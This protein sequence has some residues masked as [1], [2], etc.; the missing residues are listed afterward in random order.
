MKILVKFTLLALALC[1]SLL[2]AKEVKVSSPDGKLIFTIN[3]QAEVP[4]YSVSFNGEQVIEPS[5]LGMVF[6]SGPYFDLGFNITDSNSKSVNT[7]WQQPWGER[8][9]IT[10][11]HNELQVTIAAD[12][13]TVNTYAIY[14]YLGIWNTYEYS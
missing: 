1:S 9:T 12:R 6:K 2:A 3:D 10:D 14:L 13:E 4:K 8:E 11:H 5:R 7:S